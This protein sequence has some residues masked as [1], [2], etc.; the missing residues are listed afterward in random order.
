MALRTIRVSL[1]ILLT[2]ICAHQSLATPIVVFFLDLSGSGT[3]R[4][5]AQTSLGDNAGLAAYSVP[6]LGNVL[7]IDNR[8][9][10]V[11]NLANFAPAGFGA[12]RSADVLAAT[13]NPIISGSQD[14]VSGPTANLLF[15]FGQES[16]SYAAKGITPVFLP[17]ATSDIAWSVPMV[18]ATGT[19]N[20]STTFPEIDRSN[21]NFFASVFTMVG[22]RGVLAA[23]L[24]NPLPEPASLTLLGSAIIAAW[25]WIRRSRG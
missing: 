14:V 1:A 4:L 23:T 9:P 2:C 8:G 11:I 7:T 19:Y 24:I 6:L 22:Q 12:S 18:L 5:H 10:N 13:A 21:P 20:A 3:F 15:G 17:D 16:S 25:G